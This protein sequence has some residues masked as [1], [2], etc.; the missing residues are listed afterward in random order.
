VVDSM[1]QIQLSSDLCQAAQKKIA[2][3]F[4]TIEEFLTFILQEF[5]RDDAAAMDINE[6]RIIEARL[7]DL[8][9]I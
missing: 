3:H 1:Q 2:G 4:G 7:K 8:G 9:Y 6:Q 5:V